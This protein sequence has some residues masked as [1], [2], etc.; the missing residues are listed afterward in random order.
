MGAKTQKFIRENIDAYF[1]DNGDGTT[2]VKFGE[3]PFTMGTTHA[4]TLKTLVQKK[5]STKK[6]AFGK[7]ADQDI[8]DTLNQLAYRMVKETK[9]TPKQEEE[10]GYDKFV[11][12]KKLS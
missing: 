3:K 8:V 6:T 7:D 1:E 11:R 12:N 2:T 10:L 4:N 9:L 5:L